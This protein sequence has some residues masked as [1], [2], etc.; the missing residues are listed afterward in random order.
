[1]STLKPLVLYG[2]PVAPNP[3]K[4]AIV[5]KILNLPYTTTAIP[6]T[7]VKTPSYVAVNPNGRLPAL[8][9]PNTGIKVW[10]SGAIVEYIVDTYDKEHQLSFERA[11]KEDWEC[12]Q[13]LHFQMSGQGPYY[14]QA[15]W[16]TRMAD[17]PNPTAL[18]RYQNEVKR[19]SG[20]LDNWLEGKEF[21][22]GNKLTYVDLAF[23][24][25]QK[26]ILPAMPKEYDAA[27]E[28][29]N[30]EAWLQ[31]LLVIDGVK[32]VYEERDALVKSP[33]FQK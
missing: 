33:G 4:V 20:V 5:L 15:M 32:K 25:W 24:P 17:P 29:P 18:Q 7:E 6:I 1:M 19:V 10:E 21:L 11:T 13:W 22:V 26:A 14:G 12:K 16:F 31:R 23:V 28:F 30:V 27:K 3:V 2:S 8:E 9:D